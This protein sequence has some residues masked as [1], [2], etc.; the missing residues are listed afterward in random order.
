MTDASPDNQRLAEGSPENDDWLRGLVVRSPLLADAALRRH[1]TDVIAWLPTSARYELAS[2]L[3]DVDG[4]VAC[5]GVLLAVR[6]A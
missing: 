3:L 1:W 4:A 2:T 5:A 6:C